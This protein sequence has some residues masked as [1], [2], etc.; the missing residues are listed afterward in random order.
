MSSTEASCLKQENN[1]HYSPL[2]LAK[3][4]TEVNLEI[5]ACH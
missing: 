5:V 3:L 4:C 1:N 2:I